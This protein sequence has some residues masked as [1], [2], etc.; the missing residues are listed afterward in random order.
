M[1]KLV[2][3][4]TGCEIAAKWSTSVVARHFWHSVLKA[5]LFALMAWISV[6]N[7]CCCALILLLFFSSHP[8]ILST[9][10]YSPIR[11]DG[12]RNRGG[13]IVAVWQ[14][15]VKSVLHVD[16]CDSYTPRHIAAAIVVYSWSSIIRYGIVR[17][18][19]QRCASRLTFRVI[20][21]ASG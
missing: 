20:T 2:K 7:D 4:G 15:S 3:T 11:S 12:S 6:A 10:Y 1:S 14:L 17:L 19:V 5:L 8:Y 18:L 16:L 13:L 21:M 9:E